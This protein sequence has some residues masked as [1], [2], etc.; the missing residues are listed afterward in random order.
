MLS[1]NPASEV[2]MEYPSDGLL[3]NSGVENRH[4]TDSSWETASSGNNNSNGSGS[5]AEGNREFPGRPQVQGVWSQTRQSFSAA[6][7]EPSSSAASDAGMER[8]HEAFDYF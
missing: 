7:I 1:I 4:F 6:R 2:G 5:H 8:E 3:M